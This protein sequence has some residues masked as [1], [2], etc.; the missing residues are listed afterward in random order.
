MKKP[1]KPKM[2]KG[3]P[4]KVAMGAKKMPSV[5]KVAMARKRGM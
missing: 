2:M 3:K 4:V 5:P 1:S